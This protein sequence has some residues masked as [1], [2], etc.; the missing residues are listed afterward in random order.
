MRQTTMNSIVSNALAESRLV[1]FEELM[2]CSDP[3]SIMFRKFAASVA[4][5]TLDWV[6]QY[7]GLVPLAAKQEFLEQIK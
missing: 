1:T 6:D 3:D 5:Q 2:Q 4:Q 7:I